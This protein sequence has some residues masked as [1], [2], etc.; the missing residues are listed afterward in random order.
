MGFSVTKTENID[1]LALAI[2]ARV[3]IT[4]LAVCAVFSGA[5]LA[6]SKTGLVPS[7]AAGFLV[8]TLSIMWL[9]KMVR[10]SMRMS[11]ERVERFVK[12]SYQV[13]LICIAALLALLTSRGKL[14]LWPMLAGLTAAIFTTI[15][16]MVYLAKEEHKN[17]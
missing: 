4:N 16:T 10:K 9:M 14:E 3:L 6:L 1:S 7:F 8:G 13:R 17:A 5:L 11:P 2:S 15:C 12:F